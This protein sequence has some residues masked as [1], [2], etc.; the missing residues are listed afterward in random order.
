MAEEEKKPNEE[1]ASNSGMEK[2]YLETIKDL[3]AN[4]V[5]RDEFEKLKEDNRKLLKAIVDGRPGPTENEQKET[6][7]DLEDLRKDLFAKEHTNLDFCKKA[8]A[9]RAEILKRGD[10]DPFLPV[11]PGK[12]RIPITEEHRRA[13]QE[14]ADFLQRCID[15]ADGSPTVFT[16]T[17]ADNLTG[18]RRI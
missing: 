16:A 13:A 8:L 10:Q 2:D 17:L 4:S 18:L 3:K 12:K 6:P 15:A 9:L 7:V 1:Q 14:T 5:P 11:D